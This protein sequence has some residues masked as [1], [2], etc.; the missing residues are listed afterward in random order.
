[1]CPFSRNDGVLLS[2][3]PPT[4]EKKLA[5]QLARSHP[6]LPVY[7]IESV[8]GAL[9]ADP[10]KSNTAL[11]SNVGRLLTSIVA[12]CRLRAQPGAGRQLISDIFG[13]RKAYRD[14][15]YKTAKGIDIKGGKWLATDEG[16]IK[17]LDAV[18]R[19]IAAIGNNGM[20][21]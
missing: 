8:Y 6:D 11:S 16:R 5:P 21:I 4:F 1:M 7:I 17:L 2:D 14:G 18:D 10:P 13:R 9:L 15:S 3:S 20:Y 12:V 19:L